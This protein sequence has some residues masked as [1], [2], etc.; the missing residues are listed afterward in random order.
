MVMTVTGTPDLC[1]CCPRVQRQ[2][3][4]GYKRCSTP[5]SN[6]FVTFDE[7]CYY[8][9][10]D[11]LGNQ[12]QSNYEKNLLHLSPYHLYHKVKKGFLKIGCS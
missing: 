12:L 2:T 8:S 4:R 1:T 6:I 5:P 7:F 3:Y 10:E 11:F 9:V